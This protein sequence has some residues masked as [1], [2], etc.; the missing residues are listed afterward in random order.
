M[1]NQNEEQQ[2]ASDIE[3]RR[4]DNEKESEEARRLAHE[5]QQRD[6]ASGQKPVATSIAD[7]IKSKLSREEFSVFTDEN[8]N[9]ISPDRSS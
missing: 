4:K 8:G 3:A 9:Q 2:N 5:Q 1:I 7:S 6:I